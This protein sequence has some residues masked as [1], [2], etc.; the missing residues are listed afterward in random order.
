MSF[1]P[2]ICDL[3]DRVRLQR[4][5]A[6][7]P[8]REQAQQAMVLGMR[9]AS[10][11]HPGGSPADGL[12]DLGFPA[13]AIA[14]WTSVVKVDDACLAEAGI[15]SE[16]VDE[17]PV[18]TLRVLADAPTRAVRAAVG[19]AWLASARQTVPAAAT[20]RLLEPAWRQTEAGAYLWG[21]LAARAVLDVGTGTLTVV[22]PH[23]GEAAWLERLA[24]ELGVTVDM[25][26][27]RPTLRVTDR[28]LV[29]AMQQMGIPVAVK[30]TAAKTKTNGAAA[31]GEHEDA[32]SRSGSTK[33]EAPVIDAGQEVLQYRVPD[34][35]GPAARAAHLRGLW[36]A[37]GKA[38]WLPTG[39]PEVSWT[40]PPAMIGFVREQLGAYGLPK[41]A[42][43]A[44]PGVLRTG[45]VHLEYQGG[46]LV[47]EIRHALY[48]GASAD[49]RSPASQEQL[50]TLTAK[51]RAGSPDWLLAQ[52][53]HPGQ[54]LDRASRPQVPN[55]EPF[56]S[57][58]P[59]AL[60]PRLDEARHLL[61]ALATARG[62]Q[63]GRSLT[64]VA[65]LL[66]ASAD[67][68]TG[69]ADVLPAQLT[70]REI[71]RRLAEWQY[72]LQPSSFAEAKKVLMALGLLVKEQGKS[73][74]AA[75]TVY[76]VPAEVAPLLE[77]YTPAT[78]YTDP[79]APQWD[80]V[81]TDVLQ[82][83][84]APFVRPSPTGRRS[85]AGRTT[86]ST[87]GA[88][89][90]PTVRYAPPPPLDEEILPPVSAETLDPGLGR[91]GATKGDG[92]GGATRT[93]TRAEG[94]KSSASASASGNA[95]P[96]ATGK[97]AVTGRPGAGR[98]AGMAP[99]TKSTAG[100]MGLLAHPEQIL[101]MTSAAAASVLARGPVAK[102]DHQ[103]EHRALMAATREHL[104]ARYFPTAKVLLQDEGDHGERIENEALIAQLGLT[105]AFARL[106]TRPDFLLY[107]PDG[108][109]LVAIEA[110][111][112][113]N[114]GDETRWTQL[115]RLLD[116]MQAV[117]PSSSFVLV[118]AVT[119]N[120][121][122]VSRNADLHP[123]SFAW[124][125][126][127]EHLTPG[128]AMVR[129]DERPAPLPLDA[130]RFAAPPISSLAVTSP[131]GRRRA[132]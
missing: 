109:R 66:V 95:A 77:A 69:W 48:D 9:A 16:L 14:R 4:D 43:R 56:R 7:L 100:A 38:R 52:A 117:E 3:T 132:P 36:E 111:R 70:G 113:S 8:P 42:P 84:A 126:E 31:A 104:V 41:P 106:K 116:P 105:Q 96:T 83:G 46:M 1:D 5:I 35:M 37:T 49:L 63:L 99:A 40:A 61:H 24:T 62:V 79:V 128:R 58:V 67:T 108:A 90:R 15:P 127:Q 39:L 91:A 98:S 30:A 54:P 93:G 44:R 71:T 65:A 55:L 76:R 129:P 118:T 78:L 92:M 122:L 121:D 32:A 68:F 11:R 60:R 80:G 53:Q 12:L 13:H 28:A 45:T 125:V 102:T 115:S 26:A 75:D 17:V 123:Q 124:S 120:Q 94:T 21:H 20:A 59:A 89:R 29:S 107:E 101:A 6:A 103:V 2:W 81:L 47:E 10:L 72:T 23:R 131:R 86:P 112:T 57:S 119:R 74:A 97:P 50:D 130:T 34:G 73:A 114:P 18:E 33:S 85:G 27:P 25:D 19:S 87:T 110:V 88:T 82:H 64:S 51:V 22:A